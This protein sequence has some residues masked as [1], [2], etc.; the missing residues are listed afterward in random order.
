MPK[1]ARSTSTKRF[2]KKRRY[3]RNFKRS[4]VSRGPRAHYFKRTFLKTTLTGTGNMAAGISFQ[5]SDFPG[6]ELS[7]MQDLFDMYRLSLVKLRFMWGYTDYSNTQSSQ[8]GRVFVCKDY[9]GISVPSNGDEIM[10]YDTCKIWQLTQCDGRKAKM[11]IR[12]KVQA[13]NYLGPVSTGYT[14]KSPG[15]CN[16]TDAIPHYGVRIYVENNSPTYQGEL[17]VFATYYY[18]CKFQK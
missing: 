13:M 11:L 17:K 9:N 15:W 12:P 7:S 8:N 2:S 6:T 16:M 10:Q 3:R 5:I 4:R 1:R 14:A 18:K